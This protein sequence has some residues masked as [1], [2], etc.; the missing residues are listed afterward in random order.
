MP[1]LE[2]LALLE[3]EEGF[4]LEWAGAAD[5]ADR[6]AATSGITLGCCPAPTHW[7]VAVLRVCPAAQGV[8]I[9]RAHNSL[10]DAD[11]SFVTLQ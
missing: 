4:V 10:R 11:V 8:F 2:L 5:R 1:P 3:A 9:A 7:Q 6:C